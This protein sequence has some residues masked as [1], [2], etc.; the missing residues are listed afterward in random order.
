M[1]RYWKALIL[2]MLL[3][4]VG[5]S[6][7]GC[8]KKC[9]AGHENQGGRCVDT[10]TVTPPP[11]KKVTITKTLS[12][13]DLIHL[14]RDEI[15]PEQNLNVYFSDLRNL[16]AAAQDRNELIDSILLLSIGQFGV[17]SDG[18]GNGAEVNRVVLGKFVDSLEFFGSMK[19][20]E[21]TCIIIDG[22]PIDAISIF[23]SDSALLADKY[24]AI[25]IANTVVE[26]R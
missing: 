3:A 19:D 2:S 23:R 17:G 8:E 22:K 21:K 1:K 25:I 4:K 12:G 26:G 16:V 24:K 10:T 13:H 18:V 20:L 5:A 9:P 6:F 7:L 15:L 11:K 14:P